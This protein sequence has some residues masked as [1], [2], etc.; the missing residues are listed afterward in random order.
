MPL[1]VRDTT[2]SLPGWHACDSKLG[3]RVPPIEMG[4]PCEPGDL[5]RLNSRYRLAKSFLSIELESYGRETAEG[6]SALFLVFLCYSALEQFMLCCGIDLEDLA[7]CLTRYDAAGC[8][9][10]IRGIDSHEEFLRA[11]QHHLRSAHR[12]RFEDFLSGMPSNILYLAAGIRHI[13]AH[14]S[15]TPH[16][17][18]GGAQPAKGISTA[19]AALIFRVIEGEF[20]ARLRDNGIEVRAVTQPRGVR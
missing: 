1:I 2:I 3:Q 8:A 16:A 4:F 14:G 17:G 9:A 10:A 19:L 20:T 12:R 18:A 6:Y 13:F 15:L 7:A 5:N 11:V